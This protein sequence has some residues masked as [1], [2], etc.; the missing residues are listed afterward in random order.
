MPIRHSATA[1]VRSG[2]TLD[3]IARRLKQPISKVIQDV[4]LQAGEGD[5]KRPE[6]FYAISDSRRAAL[7]A[8][9]REVGTPD[10]VALQKP[11]AAKGLE[12]HEID[13]YCRLRDPSVFR[14]DLYEYL[15]DMEVALHR[16]VRQ[17]LVEAFG[18]GELEWWRKGVSA[19][20]RKRCVQTREDDPDPVADDFAY[21]TLI[22][23]SKIIDQN[24]KL[25]LDRLPLRFAQDRKLLIREFN[26]LNFLR[27]AV[28][29]PVK[30]R[31]WG[32]EELSFVREWCRD[33]AMPANR[34]FK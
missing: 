15:A 26:R 9:I 28:M 10:P 25:F 11:G 24:W 7:E 31:S 17:T 22:D 12:W 8:L 34:G 33:F 20:I 2:C 5:I 4:R 21:T 19:E 30:G 32:R 6:I 18:E 14:G 13:L 29:H 23:L 1:L 16:I 3:E 27:N